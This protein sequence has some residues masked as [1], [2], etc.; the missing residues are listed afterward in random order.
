M[1]ICL[2][3]QGEVMMKT[4]VSLSALVIGLTVAGAVHAAPSPDAESMSPRNGVTSSQPRSADDPRVVTGRVLKVD[5]REGTLVIQ[6]PVGVIA[7]RGPSEDLQDVSVGDIVQVEMVG[8]ENNPS[9]SPP[10]EP[11]ERN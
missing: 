2:K 6:T 9:A 3:D 11:A 4:F 7:L 10:M 8:D 5:A 1:R